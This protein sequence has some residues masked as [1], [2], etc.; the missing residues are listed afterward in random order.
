MAESIDRFL[1]SKAAK[2]NGM[3]SRSDFLI[4]VLRTWF[5][6]YEK[7]Y[8]IFVSRDSV[9]DTADRDLPKPFD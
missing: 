7:D 4:A 9:R 5:S 3:S 2:K 1:K 8:D 6:K